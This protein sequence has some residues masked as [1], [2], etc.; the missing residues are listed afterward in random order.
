MLN[1]HWLSE[2][3]SRTIGSLINVAES[4]SDRSASCGELKLTVAV[5]VLARHA[6]ASQIQISVA[7]F[8]LA[9]L[10][11]WSEA[12]MLTSSIWIRD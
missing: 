10:C 7:Y 4:R 8:V 2:D 11:A 9:Y 3:G 5:S 1:Q 6:V 12:Q